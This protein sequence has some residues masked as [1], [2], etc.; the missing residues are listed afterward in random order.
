MRLYVGMSPRPFRIMPQMYPSVR[1]FVMSPSSV[2][3]GMPYRSA[4]PLP[5]PAAPWQ[6]AQLIWKYLRPL[7]SVA[8]VATCGFTSPAIES[9][10]AGR[11]ACDTT[12]A[13]SGFPVI[14]TENSGCPRKGVVSFP[15]YWSSHG[16]IFGS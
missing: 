14:G 12:Y 4:R 8:G 16:L 5:A 7:S 6:T 1:F 9:I 2:G 11:F 3:A 13:G 10:V 15:A